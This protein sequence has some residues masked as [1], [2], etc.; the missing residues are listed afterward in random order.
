MF[1]T[2]EILVVCE[3]PICLNIWHIC[4]YACIDASVYTHT[5]TENIHVRGIHRWPL[6][7]PHKWPET[8]NMFP[9]DDVTMYHGISNIAHWMFYSVW[10]CWNKAMTHFRRVNSPNDTTMRQS[11][12]KIFQDT[13]CWLQ[14]YDDFRKWDRVKHIKKLFSGDVCHWND[15]WTAHC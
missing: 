3:Y 8:R 4:I 11:S 12:W 14:R 1:I 2:G 15:T 10:K 9:F 5:W 7:S 6:N 13:A